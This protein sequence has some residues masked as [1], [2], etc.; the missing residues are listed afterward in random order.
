MEHRLRQT[1]QQSMRLGFLYKVVCWTVYGVCLCL[2]HGYSFNPIPAEIVWGWLLIL[3]WGIGE[4]V[5]KKPLSN[6]RWEEIAKSFTSNS[7][8]AEVGLYC[9]LI[10]YS[11]LFGISN[12]GRNQREYLELQ[13]TLYNN[14]ISLLPL[15]TAQDY[16][17]HF[18]RTQRR[19]LKKILR[20][21]SGFVL[22]SE[23]G[24][25]TKNEFDLP[26]SLAILRWVM[27]VK[28]RSYLPY[29]SLLS[30]AKPYRTLEAEQILSLATQCVSAL[31]PTKPT[32]PTP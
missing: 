7:D 26:I 3:T 14:L 22:A 30:R 18:D 10:T 21:H 6:D 19:A 8:I 15:V 4:T 16:A 24:G 13:R 9:Q 20:T 5:C 11:P 29:L 12:F 2:F 25:Y 23:D 31:K 1:L 17:K 27:I 28:D 32:T